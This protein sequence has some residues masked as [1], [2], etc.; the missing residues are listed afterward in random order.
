[1]REPCRPVI[2]AQTNARV[3]RSCPDLVASSDNTEPAV[4]V[5]ELWWLGRSVDACASETVAGRARRQER[6]VYLM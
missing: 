2:A 4:E 3:L 5:V 1:M 6:L